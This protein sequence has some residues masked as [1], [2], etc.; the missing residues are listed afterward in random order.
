MNIIINTL[1]RKLG[2]KIIKPAP[3]IIKISDQRKSIHK[4][5]I[6]DVRHDV[7]GIVIRT[8]LIVID[9]INTEDNYSLLWK[10]YG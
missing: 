5:I 6:Q 1:R 2:L 4:G 3:F 9:I 10:D 7:G 8:T